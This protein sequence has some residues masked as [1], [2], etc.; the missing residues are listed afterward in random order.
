MHADLT[1]S[2]GKGFN[3]IFPLLLVNGSGPELDLRSDDGSVVVGYQYRFDEANIVGDDA[4]HGTASCDYRGTGDM[5]LV[6]SVYF[7]DVNPNNIDLFWHDTVDVPYPSKDS[8][9]GFFSS[10]IGSHW[11]A[12]VS[13][14]RLPR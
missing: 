3:I 8:F 1:N 4:Y 13:S 14:V 10:R 6:V 5:R 2:G 12:N 9:R 11:N 7:A